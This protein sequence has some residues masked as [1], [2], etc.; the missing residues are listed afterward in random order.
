MAYK[1][2]RCGKGRMVLKSGRHH[3]GVAG[4]KW[5]QRAPKT[6]KVSRP[7]LHPFK[8]VLRTKRQPAGKTGRWRLC[9]KCLRI[10]K[11]QQKAIKVKPKG[12]QGKS[13]RV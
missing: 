7:N 2:D 11:K 10:V 13:F 6:R 8:G 3:R 12:S 4:G 1:C 5:K 9:T